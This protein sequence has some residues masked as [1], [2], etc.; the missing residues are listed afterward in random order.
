MLLIDLH[1]YWD[2]SRDELSDRTGPILFWEE[3]ISWLAKSRRI[4]DVGCGTGSALHSFAREKKGVVGLTPNWR[5]REIGSERLAQAGL[6]DA[7]IMLGDAHNI[8]LPSGY[9]DGVIC[10]DVLEHCVSPYIVLCE[11]LRICCEGGR[12]IIF[13]PGQGWQEERYHLLVPTIRQMRHLLKQAGWNLD[14]VVD[15]SS[16]TLSDRD[17][18]DMAIYLLSKPITARS[19]N[20]T[21]K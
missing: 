2:P 17:S 18:D 20:P 7:V 11:M 8:P 10:W 4:C 14:N 5:E 15:K 3:T 1:Q 9:C 21:V 6:H 13:L 16:Y 19:L 12:G